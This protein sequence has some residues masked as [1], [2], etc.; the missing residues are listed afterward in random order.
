[1]DSTILEIEHS[2]AIATLWLNRPA[3]HNALN[4]ALIDALTHALN[5]LASDASVRVI[6]LAGRGASF[7]A[8]ADLDW[9]RRAAGFSD[10]QN[11]ADAQALA[12]LLKT[13]YRCPKPVIARVHG[14][15][16]AG[17]MGLV[18]A[19]DIAIAT[20]EARF[21]LSEVRLGLIPATIA[22]YV[23]EAI[24]LRAMR[25]YTLS[26]ERLQADTA[27]RLGLIHEIVAPDMLDSSIAAVAQQL[28]QGAPGALA[29]SKKLLR[30]VADGSTSDD[31][32]LA[33]TAALIARTRAGSE[34]REGLAAFFDKR[35]PAWQEEQD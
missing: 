1:M 32:L 5:A 25:R 29:Q 11:L 13:L 6:V 10:A 8:G 16:L 24:G 17:G 21:G 22:P 12:T 2:A 30:A 27:W 9:M 28:V 3:L 26:A 33:E 23:S 35:R 34:A 18:A 7:C 20:P 14:A 15:A 19:C 31:A 4:E